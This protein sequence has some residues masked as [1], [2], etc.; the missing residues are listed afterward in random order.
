MGGKG[1]TGERKRIEHCRDFMGEIEHLLAANLLSLPNNITRKVKKAKKA[2][3]G[4]ID[5]P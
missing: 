5:G 4:R 3:E 1:G 2:K